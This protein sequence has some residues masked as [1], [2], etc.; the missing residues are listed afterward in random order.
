M[1]KYKSLVSSTVKKLIDQGVKFDLRTMDEQKAVIEE[2]LIK[3]RNDT[4]KEAAELAKSDKYNYQDYYNGD[5]ISDALM[6]L[7]DES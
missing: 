3:M 5:G 6:K 2:A 7:R 1:R 4:L